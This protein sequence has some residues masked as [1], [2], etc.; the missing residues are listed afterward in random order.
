MDASKVVL[1]G[2]DIA[3]LLYVVTTLGGILLDG[4]QRLVGAHE[5]T[6]LIVDGTT[7]VLRV[8]DS[9]LDD[10]R[11]EL[12]YHVLAVEHLDDDIALCCGD[13]LHLLRSHSQERVEIVL[14]VLVHRCAVL[15]LARGEPL[16]RTLLAIFLGDGGEVGTSGKGVVDRVGTSVSLIRCRTANLNGTELH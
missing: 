1:C 8:I 15:I 16:L 9:L 5:S 14:R 7:S 6:E 4:V 11:G 2:G 13:I 10:S 3:S 12:L